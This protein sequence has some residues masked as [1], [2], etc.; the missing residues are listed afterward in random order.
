MSWQARLGIWCVDSHKEP[1]GL[2]EKSCLG[3]RKKGWTLKSDT[4]DARKEVRPKNPA[5]EMLGLILLLIHWFKTMGFI[6]CFDGPKVAT[7]PLE[8][9]STF[10]QSQDVFVFHLVA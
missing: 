9:V 2:N 1:V 3:C 5:P 10:L 4:R 6:C 8:N 7:P